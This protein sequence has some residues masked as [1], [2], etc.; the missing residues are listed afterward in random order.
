MNEPVTARALIDA[1]LSKSFA[2]FVVKG[3]RSLSVSTALWLLDDHG[4]MA[5]PLEGKSKREVE[6]LRGLYA[7][8]PPKSVRHRLAG[9]HG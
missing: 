7:P 8:A 4:L 5:G 1:G 6:T 2:H 9:A 3:E